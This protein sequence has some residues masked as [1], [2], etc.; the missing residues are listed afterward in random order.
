MTDGNKITKPEQGLFVIC[1]AAFL[2]PFM[3]SALNL[4]LPQ[5]S[6]AFSMDAVTLTW[7]NTV[8]IISAAVFQIP[9]ARIADLV[10]RKKV[11]FIGVLVFSVSM[12]L[13]GFAP[14][15]AALIILRFMGGMG[16]AMMFGTNI[17]IL[18]ALF[19]P[20]K[21]GYALGVNAAVVYA[22]LAAGPVLGGFLARYFGWQSIFFFSAGV[23]VLV[24]LFIRL[25]MRSEWVESKGEKLDIAGS[26]LFGTGLGALIYGFTKLPGLSGIVFVSA[27]MISFVLFALYESGHEYPV[28]DV[29]LF[30]RNRVFRLSSVAAL[31][32]YAAT[33][34]VAFML[35]LYLQYIRGLDAGAA[36]LVL[37]SQA[38][39]Q[40]AFSLVAGRLSGRF[41]SSKLATSGMVLT[42]IGLG[43]LAA[44]TPLT[45]FWVIITLLALLGM[46]F[47]IFSA[48][49]TNVIMGAVDKKYYSAA[50]AATGTMRLT[51]QAFSMGIAAMAISVNI[52]TN[53]IVPELFPE[54]MSGFRAT[55]IIFML[56][57]AVGIYASSA[58]IKESRD[59]LVK[60]NKIR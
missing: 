7:V 5:I 24:L 26:V 58:R 14:G 30:S 22:A 34:A 60:E 17:A 40:S 48:P 35:S 54:F 6:D 27:G 1:T 42:V 3:G 37:I 59:R 21:R 50:S 16:S 18:T 31:I 52:G 29:R 47:G 56:L 49:N 10:G 8:Y 9:F 23:G 44:L 2:V 25:F 20:E 32:N 12:F 38:L 13:C 46:G 55:F 36:G 15:A 53:K 51:G 43:G 57:C 4:A 11:F 41:S 33:S 19:P 45:P 39:V 28:F